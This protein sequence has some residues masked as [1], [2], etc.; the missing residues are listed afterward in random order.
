MKVCHVITRMIV[1]GAQ[2]NT[3]F[4]VRGL[5]EASHECVLMTGP[6]PGPEGELLKK[7]ASG[8]FT[9]VE[10]PYLVRE[11]SPLNEIKAYLFMKK[12]F[13]ENHFDV[14][15]THSSK[16]GIIG[17]FAA[18]AA[19]VPV[20]VHT[21]HGLA[22]NQYEKPWKNL[23]YTTL[24]RAAAKR[25]DK[26]YAVA[27]AMIEQSLDAKIGTRELYKV[28]YSGMELGDF[29]ESKR[30]LTLRRTLGIPEN[31]IVLGT[32]A[33][34]FEMKGYEDLFKIAPELFKRFKNL[35][36]LIVGDG[37]M[38]RELEEKAE[39]EHFRD[40]ISFAG[41]VPPNDVPQ[42]A[43]QMDMLAHFSL[44]E[45]LPRA[46]VQALASGKPVAA[47]SLDGTPEVVIDKVTGRLATPCDTQSALEAVT[48][49]LE[50][51]QFRLDAGKAGRELV[52]EK[53][54]WRKMSAILIGEYEKLIAGKRKKS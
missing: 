43:A 48:Y 29:L 49:I 17:R 9:V 13:T 16:A 44:R 21:I 14:V 27:Q 7:G 36:F 37:L 52:K 53:F 3:L 30:D 51:E 23:I 28:V 47:Y 45:G 35:H 33:R 11:I 38:R 22:F 4:S 20:V 41:L 39:K 12:Y 8:G 18:H 54:N 15:H 10:C 19:H 1:G 2:E 25:S 31:A 50:N 32:I 40:K 6:S 24:E 34:L 42:Y 5:V 26:I 46:A